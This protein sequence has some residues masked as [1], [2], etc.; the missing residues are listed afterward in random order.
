[1][2]QILTRPGDCKS[3]THRFD[4]DPR[5]HSHQGEGGLVFDYLTAQEKDSFNNRR[6]TCLEHKVFLSD[7]V[8]V[9]IHIVDDG[10]RVSLRF[11]YKG[12]KH[13]QLL[14]CPLSELNGKDI[15]ALVKKFVGKIDNARTV[16]D[17]LNFVLEND[18]CG[19]AYST[20]KK[21]DSHFRDLCNRD[22]FD[23]S[24]NTKSLHRLP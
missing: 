9:N 22:G 5:L 8:S 21:N 19:G 11:S 13:K 12:H 16:E 18:E 1:M 6:L 10:N 7:F 3:S 4:S 14:N 24:Q 15:D 23:L 17:V 20:R 2:N